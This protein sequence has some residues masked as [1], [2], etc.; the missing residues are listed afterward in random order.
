MNYMHDLAELAIHKKI[1]IIVTNQLMKADNIEYEK[2]NYSISNYTHQKI[3]L[4]KQKDHYKGVVLAPYSEKTQFF[5]K[6]E[7]IGL[8]ER[9]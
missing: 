8:V 3:K 6:I 7:K 2:M 1:P 9:S 4:E 5:Y